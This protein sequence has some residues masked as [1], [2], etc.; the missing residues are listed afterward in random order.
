M[1]SNRKN[2]GHSGLLLQPTTALNFTIEN[3]R[4]LS[5]LG[6]STLY[7]LADEG[8]LRFVKV[9]GRTLVDGNSLRALMA[10]GAPSSRTGSRSG[11]LQKSSP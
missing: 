7:K 3:A 6:R 5:G 8:R 1:N 9:L 2:T 4:L 10:H 11:I